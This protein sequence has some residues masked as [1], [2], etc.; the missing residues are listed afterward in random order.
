MRTV[1]LI[2]LLIGFGLGYIAGIVT[3]RLWWERPPA[4]THAHQDAYILGR[5][6]H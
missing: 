6:A 4:V 2:F 1:A 3:A 5:E